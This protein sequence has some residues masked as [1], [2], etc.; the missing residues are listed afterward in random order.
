VVALG[1]ASKVAALT[2]AGISVES[3]IPDFRSPGGL[4]SV[5]E[6]EQYATL[7]VF[8]RDSSKAWRLYR[9]LGRTLEGKKPN[10]AHQALAKLEDAGI[11]DLVVTQNV[12]GLHQ[13]A[14]SQNVIEMHGDHRSLQ[15]IKCGWLGPVLPEHLQPES[16]IPSCPE[17][18]FPLKPNVVLFGEDVREMDTA[19][20]AMVTC[21]V[22][23]VIGTSARV[24]PAA[25]LPAVVKANGGLIYEFNTQPTELTRGAI[26]HG[27]LSLVL[28]GAVEGVRTDYFFKGSAGKTLDFFAEA[29]LG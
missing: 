4:W 19:S 24:Y 17:C 1:Q 28:Q 8:L 14:G 10:P 16:S 23:L 7:E 22:L 11:L 27:W 25:S 26:G 15:C 2:G 21:D 12:D 5:F 20:Q 6:P 18:G 3:G 9:A 29:V 13:A